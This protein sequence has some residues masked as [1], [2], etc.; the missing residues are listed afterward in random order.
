MLYHPDTKAKL[1]VTTLGFDWYTCHGHVVE[2][3]DTVSLHCH[4]G[5]QGR[6]PGIGTHPPL[7]LV[8]PSLPLA[9]VPLWPS[10]HLSQKSEMVCVAS[11]SVLQWAIQALPFIPRP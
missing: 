8:P 2:L 5:G 4:I 9:L 10:R 7:V 11:T 3:L 6:C 1:Q